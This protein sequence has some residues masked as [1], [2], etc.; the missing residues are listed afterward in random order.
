M[1]FEVV[2]RAGRGMGVLDGVVMVEGKGQFWRVNL[3]RPIVTSA[4][5]AMHSSEI[6]LRTCLF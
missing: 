5:F 1:L 6:N 3:R 4:I 2:S